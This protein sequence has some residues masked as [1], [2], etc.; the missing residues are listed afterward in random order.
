VAEPGSGRRGA[1]QD[2]AD[3]RE[4][5]REFVRAVGSGPSAD[6]AVPRHVVLMMDGSRRWARATGTPL[7][8]TYRLVARRTAVLV[9]CC[10]A[11]GVQVVTVWGSSRDNHRFRPLS[12]M[13][14][15][16]AGMEEGLRRVASV[17]DRRIEPI[18]QL[19]L[20]PPS[21]RRLL[22]DLRAATRDA[23]A[24]AF[25]V[26]AA[27][28][29]DGRSEIAGAA[30][31]ALAEV[32]GRESDGSPAAL[33]VASIARHLPTFG[34]PDPELVIRTSGQRR[35]SGLL[36]WQSSHA[37]IHTCPKYCPEFTEADLAEAFHT[38]AAAV[39]TFGR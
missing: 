32:G 1:E 6:A 18:G 19:G 30:R 8:E 20:A 16:V 13:E 14:P 4:R 27:I 2:T 10:Q 7:L 39:R 29:Y 36:L 34:Q 22:A 26:N 28:A 25:T 11:V 31:R 15:L 12:E 17:P 33:T 35:L 24:A 5:V 21:T 38:F 3:D 37:E 23:D 9:S